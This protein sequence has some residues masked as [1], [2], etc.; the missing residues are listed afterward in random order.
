MTREEFIKVLEEKDYSYEI[1]G[2]KIVVTGGY[3][4]LNDLTS[5]PPGVVFNNGW[6]VNLTSLTSLPAGVV[7]RNKESVYLR[8]LTSLSP[9]VEFNNKGYV[10]LDSLTGDYFNR[11]EGNIEGVNS[12]RL[13]NKMITL[14][15][16]D[17][18]K[19]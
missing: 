11:W 9:D 19:R 13:L 3:I 14:G 17:K 15:L 5:I 18:N 10:L 8:S 4:G 2:N 7:F 12:K 6:A 16:F 1:Q